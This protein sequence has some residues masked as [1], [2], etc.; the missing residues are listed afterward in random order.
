MKIFGNLVD[1]HNR[2]IFPAEIAV[3]KGRIESIVSVVSC[4]DVYI[5][6]GLIDSHIHIESSMLTPGAFAYAAVEHGTV[7]EMLLRNMFQREYPLTTNAALL[8]KQ[9]KKFHWE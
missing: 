1:I 8:K 7:G 5:L 6:P 9:E 4:P 2:I 3:F